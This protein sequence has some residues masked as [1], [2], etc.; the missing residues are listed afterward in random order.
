MI[1]STS[2]LAALSLLTL[3][4]AA[5]AQPQY[6]V[7]AGDAQLCDDADR[8]AV[9]AQVDYEYITSTETIVNVMSDASHVY[10]A[11]L[12]GAIYRV[13]IC[14][15]P[16]QTV[17]SEPGQIYTLKLV[18]AG[19]YL[20]AQSRSDA[21][22]GQIRRI[23]KSDLEL[24]VLP[25]PGASRNSVTSRPL[26]ANSM[27]AYVMNDD[28]SVLRL[29]HT[30]SAFQP[31]AAPTQQPDP[32]KYWYDFYT[33]PQE[34]LSTLGLGP[35]G[36]VFMPSNRA[37]FAPLDG[38]GVRVLFDN[39]NPYAPEA[40]A[41][42]SDVAYFASQGPYY[43]EQIAVVRRVDLATGAVRLTQIP[44][45]TKIRQPTLQGGNLYW[46]DSSSVWRAP[47]EDPTALAR[48][49][50][51]DIAGFSI[52]NGRV[53]SAT[54]TFVLSR[55]A[56]SLPLGQSFRDSSPRTPV[57]ERQ[58]QGYIPEFTRLSVD[59][60]GATLATGSTYTPVD[61]GGGALPVTYNSMQVFAVKYDARGS[62]AWSRV[63]GPGPTSSCLGVDAA[64]AI[65]ATQVSWDNGPT[66]SV[67]TQLIKLSSA[68]EEIWRREVGRAQYC[69]VHP[70]GDVFL[71][72]LAGGERAP[73]QV[74]AVRPDGTFGWSVTLNV[75]PAAIS[76]VATSGSNV[77]VYASPSSLDPSDS[78]VLLALDAAT[79]A[80]RF[81]KH[82]PGAMIWELAP[83]RSGGVAAL[84]VTRHLVDFGNGVERVPAPGREANFLVVYD[85]S[86]R[87]EWSK[88]FDQGGRIG[89]LATD[90]SGNV[91]ITGTGGRSSPFVLDPS[92][93]AAARPLDRFLTRFDSAGRWQW[94]HQ[95]ATS[96]N[97]MYYAPSL[98]AGPGGVVVSREEPYARVLSKF[99]DAGPIIPGCTLRAQP[100]AGHLATWSTWAALAALG[101]YRRRAR[102]RH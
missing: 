56:R 16:V 82:I 96:S 42:G 49:A 32:L 66:E 35:T 3:P 94:T 57:W 21:F 58:F 78:S 12:T 11:L 60:T 22:S 29:A 52:L 79:G 18:D 81:R 85:S 48:V 69:A 76:Y 34:T 61:L 54:R 67:P 41:V 100:K 45:V 44:P 98:G 26:V 68:G 40:V 97:Q 95:W 73:P 64:G 80:E 14:G 86:G 37:Y 59:A 5:L 10:F 23:R 20:Y 88:L 83:A 87:V 30:D 63:L 33:G 72:E 71:T 74:R 39:G 51:T 84:G 70:S 99:V 4:G 24:E 55:P 77:F 50:H 27:H 46:S 2:A 1:R 43:G 91:F 31:F 28:G 65:I 19:A 93:S 17:A 92:V 8:A 101:L 62:H 6:T 9:V 7:L 47:A 36:I 25:I 38:S 90:P 102:R 75:A 53:Y 89:E 13:P 15:G